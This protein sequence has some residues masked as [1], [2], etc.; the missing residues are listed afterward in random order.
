MVIIV[1]GLPGSGKSYFA[2][3]LASMINADYINSD[4]LRKEI[5]AN[6]TYSENEK[7]AVYKMMLSKLIDAKNQNKN[8][9]L[10]GTFYKDEIRRIFI[11]EV[12]KAGG[13][14][15]IEVIAD[16]NLINDRLQK[17]REDSE[18]DFEVYKKIK[19]Q[20]QPL[21]EPHL[22]LKSTNDN[23]NEMLDK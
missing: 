6:R 20:W 16:E 12:D 8:V 1:F 3:R 15:F 23:I 19:A 17:T 11:D 13:I 9:V 2:C 22:V 21:D 5:V 4:K 14:V 7:L 18:A 10:D